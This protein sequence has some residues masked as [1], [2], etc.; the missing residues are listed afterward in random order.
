MVLNAIQRK[1]RLM[2]CLRTIFQV[3]GILRCLKIW[4]LLVLPRVLEITIG[5]IFPG[6]HRRRLNKSNLSC[7]KSGKISTKAHPSGNQA[8]NYEA[9]NPQKFNQNHL[10][11]STKKNKKH[12]TNQTSKSTNTVIKKNSTSNNSKN[13]PNPIKITQP[14]SS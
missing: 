2:V 3:L 6:N 1:I 13:N 10:H 7:F 11:K 4:L 14:N 9:A 5:R 8:K 12:G